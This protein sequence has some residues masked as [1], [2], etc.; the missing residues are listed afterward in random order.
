[1]MSLLQSFTEVFVPVF[2][3]MDPLMILPVFMSLTDGMNSGQKRVLAWRAVLTA[4]FIAI[5]I[6]LT[7]QALFRVLGI[8]IDDLRVAG[9]II[10][11]II[12]IYDLV[13][14]SGE[15]KSNDVGP[16]AGVVPLGT[17]LIVGPAVMT[18]CVVLA[19]SH[20]RTMVIVS[21]LLNLLIVWLVLHFADRAQAYIRP[22]IT[23]AFGKVMSLFL[24]A[25][26]VAMA[27]A[28]LLEFI[29]GIAKALE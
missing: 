15:R 6:V 27:R 16:D 19:D 18:A 26:A 21:L 22:S 28:G 5:A 29:K 2:V 20:G 9:G 25:I 8:T 24:A 12:A 13:F 10:L 23:K 14:A 17:P 1:M 7:G 4:F 11:L 3:A